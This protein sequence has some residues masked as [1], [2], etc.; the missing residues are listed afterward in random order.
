MKNTLIIIVICLL[1]AYQRPIRIGF[2][3]LYDTDFDVKAPYKIET[4]GKYYYLSRAGI[5]GDKYYN[6]WF[7]TDQ[8]FTNDIA[9][10]KH[11]VSEKHAKRFYY[12]YVLK[13]QQFKQSLKEVK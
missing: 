7:I 8:W 12:R 5:F 10:P 2:Y 3:S 1:A 4:D 11:F 9:N 6:S 13:K